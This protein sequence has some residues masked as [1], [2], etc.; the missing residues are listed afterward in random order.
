LQKFAQLISWFP[1]ETRLNRA[2][3]NFNRIHFVAHLSNNTTIQAFKS[4]ILASGDYETP[5]VFQVDSTTAEKH[6]L[7]VIQIKSPVLPDSLVW[8]ALNDTAINIK[9]WHLGKQNQLVTQPLALYGTTLTESHRAEVTAQG[10][11]PA[12]GQ[13]LFNLGAAK[14]NWRVETVLLKTAALDQTPSEIVN[15]M[16]SATILVPH[17]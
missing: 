10:A 14:I 17:N 12:C 2:K 15:L 4:T 8:E 3:L 11:I 7:A 6:V 13:F 9:V 5:E 16:L 1:P